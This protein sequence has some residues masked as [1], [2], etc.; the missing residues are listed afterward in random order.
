MFKRGLRQLQRRAPA[1]IES[2]EARKLLAGTISGT[3]FGD[4]NLDGIKQSGEKGFAN[5]QIYIDRNFDGKRQSNEPI[6]TTN[7]KGEFGFTGASAGLYRLRLLPTTGYRQT[8]PSL[9]YIDVS[10]SGFGDTH[11]GQNFGITPSGIISGTVFRD[12]NRD[13][14]KQVN[15]FGVSNVTIFIDKNGNGRWD[16]G[17]K[18]TKTDGVGAWSISGLSAAKYTVRMSIPKGFT[19]TAGQKGYQKITLA[20]AQIITNRNWGV[21]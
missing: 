12:V 20:K 5:Q 15:E 14:V 1:Q 11:P 19:Y 16:T 6:S 18:K 13:G 2:L 9:G 4:S 17:E 3:V 21:I 7:S 10:V 8:T